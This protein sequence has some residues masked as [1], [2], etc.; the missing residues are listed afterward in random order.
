[1]MYFDALPKESL[2][3]YIR[4]IGTEKEMSTKEVLQWA[5]NKE[6]Q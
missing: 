2:P 4:N 1:M 5:Q 6:Q 3:E